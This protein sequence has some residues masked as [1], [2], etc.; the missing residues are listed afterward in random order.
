MKKLSLALITGGALCAFGVL[1]GGAALAMTSFEFSKVVTTMKYEN[2]TAAY[3]PSLLA[4]IEIAA[5]DLKVVVSPSPDEQVHLSYWESALDATTIEVDG[6]MLR[7]RHTVSDSWLDNFIHG[8]WSSFARYRHVIEIKIPA[9]FAGSLSVTNENAALEASGLTALSSAAFRSKMVRWS[10]R[11]S[12][13][14]AG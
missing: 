14:W 7:F 13:A 6:G 5:E 12:S 4:G 10:S 11:I 8:F 1:L 9:S 2:K 3:E